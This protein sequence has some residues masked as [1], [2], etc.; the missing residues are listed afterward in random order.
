MEKQLKVGDVIYGKSIYGIEDPITIERVT[1]TQ[2]ISGNKKFRINYQ[3]RHPVK[4]IGQSY[5]F[6][7]TFY[8][9]EDEEIKMEYLKRDAFYKCGQINF[10]KLS[11]EQLNKILE[12]VTS[13]TT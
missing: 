6:E 1:K 12:I 3:E 9:V 11:Y 5:G 8:Y 13:K 2:A 7:S 4:L 10:K